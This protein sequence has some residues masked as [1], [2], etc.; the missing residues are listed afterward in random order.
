MYI[1]LSSIK[2]VETA[3]HRVCTTLDCN[4]GSSLWPSCKSENFRD[5]RQKGVLR[6]EGVLPTEAYQTTT[7]RCSSCG[8]YEFSSPSPRSQAHSTSNMAEGPRRKHVYTVRMI[9]IL[10]HVRT[11]K[12][13]TRLSL[14][15]LEFRFVKFITAFL[16]VPK[17]PNWYTRNFHPSKNDDA[18]LDYYYSDYYL[19][20]FNE[21]WQVG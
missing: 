14:R 20:Q 1:Y 6:Q 9:K 3:T 8:T 10:L 15:C 19:L 7:P 16:K 5:K 4:T 13:A 21:F 11:C 17:F 12:W 18:P 2:I